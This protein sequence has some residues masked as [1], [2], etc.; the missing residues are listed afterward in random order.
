MPGAADWYDPEDD[1]LYQAPPPGSGPRDLVAP[2]RQRVVYTM[3]EGGNLT[4]AAADVANDP[5]A[6]SRIAARNGIANPSRVQAGRQV[7]ITPADVGSLPPG[8]GAV[9]QRGDTA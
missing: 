7:V 4:E 5:S 3:P 8:G 2:D 6:A 9:V 1:P